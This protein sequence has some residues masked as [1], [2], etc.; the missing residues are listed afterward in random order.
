MSFRIKIGKFH[1]TSRRIAQQTDTDSVQGDC[2]EQEKGE[3]MS[4][5][6]MAEHICGV[7]RKLE[8]TMYRE[9]NPADD[10]QTSYRN[11]ICYLERMQEESSACGKTDDSENLCELIGRLRCRLEQNR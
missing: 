3:N 1:Y 6:D 4:V 8:E 9:G 2:K 5:S 10:M 11:M 7:Y